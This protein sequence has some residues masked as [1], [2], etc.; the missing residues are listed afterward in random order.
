MRFLLQAYLAYGIG[1]RVKCISILKVENYNKSII[2]LFIICYDQL[3]Y[4]CNSKL[5]ILQAAYNV[6][7]HCFNAHDIQSSI[8]RIRSHHSAS[9]CL[10]HQS[11]TNIMHTYI[12]YMNCF[13]YIHHVLHESIYDLHPNRKRFLVLFLSLCLS[14]LVGLYKLVTSPENRMMVGVPQPYWTNKASR[15]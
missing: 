15:D 5:V 1:N 9:V 7:G 4:F 10:L 12:T 3:R 13:Y 8:L 2:N 11:S 14:V 6:G